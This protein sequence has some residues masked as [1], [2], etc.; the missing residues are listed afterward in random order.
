[1]A[2]LA[3]LLPVLGRLLFP[4]SSFRVIHLTEEDFVYRLSDD[5]R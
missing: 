4:S 2:V 1:M 3:V 5:T